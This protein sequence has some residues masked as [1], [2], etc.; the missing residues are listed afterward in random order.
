M[1]DILIS[2]IIPVYNVAKY[3][4]QCLNSIITQD[5]K[6]VE[7]IC[8]NDC[9]TDNSLEILE[10]YSKK[11]SR[12]KILN[13]DKNYGVGI[14]RNI[15][16]DATQEGGYVHFVDPDDWLE[17]NAYSNLTK[18]LHQHQNLDILYFNY[19]VF[20]N[21]T[22]K[23]G[24]KSFKNQEILNKV[25]HPIKD[26]QAFENW[27]R[28]CWLK[29]LRKD[30][31]IKNNIKFR[32]YK[33][34]SDVEWAALIYTKAESICYVND[35]IVNYRMFRENSLVMQVDKNI[36]DIIKV[37]ENTKA[38]Y[39]DLPESIKYKMLGFDYYT[40]KIC[41]EYAFNHGGLSLFRLFTLVL[42]L[43]VKDLNKYN[44]IYLSK[45]DYCLKLKFWKTFSNKYCPNLY[46][47]AISLK[48][49]ILA[50]I[51]NN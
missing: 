46:K 32:N 27:D 49:S 15:G 16:L 28:Y 36:E 44:Y 33:S 3:L 45:E 12:I 51:H 2:I 25:F 19:K 18:Y 13:N 41:I 24:L 11:D 50:C 43:N 30:F 14:S 8:V 22:A 23:I 48:K 21:R 17:D 7:I 31:L 5:Y 38:V 9:S 6:N 10:E 35:V 37:V 47:K 39:K 40:E 34:L 26:E 4:P 42:K 1:K 20:N 29:L